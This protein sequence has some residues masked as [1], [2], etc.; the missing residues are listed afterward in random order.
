MIWL[1]EVVCVWI[2]RR[3]CWCQ[4]PT[5]IEF[6]TCL[7]S[8]FAEAMKAARSIRPRQLQSSYG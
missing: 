1:V 4:F 8:M 7:I 3:E 2:L 5:W 6:R